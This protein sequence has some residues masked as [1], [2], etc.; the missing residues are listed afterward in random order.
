MGHI[1]KNV[2]HAPTT[3]LRSIAMNILP[4][5]LLIF[6]RVQALFFEQKYY[7]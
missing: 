2:L 3:E 4:Y 1:L 5:I 6:V 7:G